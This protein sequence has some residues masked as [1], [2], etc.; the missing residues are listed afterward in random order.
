MGREDSSHGRF[1]KGH[2]SLYPNCFI[3][4]RP[5]VKS[6]LQIL[7]PSDPNNDSLRPSN[8]RE[9][10]TFTPTT[11]RVSP[12]IPQR[13]VVLNTTIPRMGADAYP[14]SPIVDEFFA[15]D[16]TKQY[17]AKACPTGVPPLQCIEGTTSDAPYELRTLKRQS[18][19]RYRQLPTSVK[20]HNMYEARKN[21]IIACH[22]CS[23][24]EERVVSN[25]LLA[26][27]M[28]F[29][30]AESNRACNRNIVSSGP[31]EDMMCRSVE[32]IYM[33]AVNG[34]GVF[35]TACTDGQA[36]YEAYLCAVRGKATEFRANQYSKAQKAGAAFA[37]RK[38]AIARNHICVYED[39]LYSRYPRLAGSMRPE[40]GYYSKLTSLILNFFMWF[41]LL[42]DVL[43]QLFSHRAIFSRSTV[44][45]QPDWW[46]NDARWRRC[47]GRW[48]RHCCRCDQPTGICQGESILSGHS[49]DVHRV[50]LSHASDL[51]NLDAIPSYA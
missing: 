9:R 25:P 15:K 50:K 26:N 44:R 27:A 36:K 18:Q 42:A 12:R 17:I 21:A 35:S 37:A 14:Y 29:G 1:Q 45:D 38:Q 22:G 33:K 10:L 3:H 23:H 20:V 39:K 16:V 40:F 28:T 47:K 41:G 48:I 7:H 32:N 13:N 43:T 34:S 30:Q 46:Y 6:S 49:V 51:R 4:L 8:S 24:E 5:D 2:L 31:A 11:N 19:L